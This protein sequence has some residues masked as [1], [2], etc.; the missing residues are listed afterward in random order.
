MPPKREETIA[1]R[2]TNNQQKTAK[3]GSRQKIPVAAEKL[4][5]ILP[6]QRKLSKSA[7]PAVPVFR[8][9]QCRYGRQCRCVKA[10]SAGLLTEIFFFLAIPNSKSRDSG[11]RNCPKQW[12]NLA[13]TAPN[14]L[15]L[16]LL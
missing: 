11:R 4:A 9:R 1:V 14:F 15:Q 8:G 13:Q 5:E 12:Q 10:G 7:R 16:N 3:T 2:E 6:R